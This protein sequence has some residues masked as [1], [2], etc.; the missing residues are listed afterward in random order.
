MKPDLPDQNLEMT[1]APTCVPNLLSSTIQL[2][3]EALEAVRGSIN[4]DDFLADLLKGEKALLGRIPIINSYSR[5][6]RVIINAA[7]IELSAAAIC[8]VCD[9]PLNAGAKILIDL[10][11]G[12]A[13]HCEVRACALLQAGLCRLTATYL[14][15]INISS[16]YKQREP[17]KAVKTETLEGLRGDL[18]DKE[19]REIREL[20]MRLNLA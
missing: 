14:A 3:R 17:V 5:L 2:S 13:I 18:S 6:T 11:K 1:T 7:V 20:E 9:Y 10:G 19:R 16:A 4:A 12:R 15:E 8:L